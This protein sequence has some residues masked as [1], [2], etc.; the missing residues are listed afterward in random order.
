MGAAHM[1]MP[2]PKASEHMCIT[3]LRQAWEKWVSN[4]CFFWGS[5]KCSSD[6]AAT[7]PCFVAFTTKR[8]HCCCSQQTRLYIHTYQCANPAGWLSHRLPKCQ[9]GLLVCNA[10]N[11]INGNMAEMKK[12]WQSFPKGI[13][14]PWPGRTNREWCLFTLLQVKNKLAGPAPGWPIA[15][16]QKMLVH[17]FVQVARKQACIWQKRQTM[18]DSLWAGLHCPRLEL[19]YTCLG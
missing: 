2:V 9:H 17:F 3:H 12:G 13:S 15:L 11:L 4:A 6:T 10:L 14:S 1:S 16:L 8:W 18:A 19:T 7:L 5:S